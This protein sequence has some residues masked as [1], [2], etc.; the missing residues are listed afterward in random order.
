LSDKQTLGCVKSSEGRLGTKDGAKSFDFVHLPALFNERNIQ[1]TRVPAR[2]HLAGF[3]QKAS[4]FIF[5]GSQS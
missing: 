3:K 2:L 4:G 5:G 1:Q